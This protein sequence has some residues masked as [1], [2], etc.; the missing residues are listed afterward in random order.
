MNQ[1]IELSRILGNRPLLTP[2]NETG[3]QAKR[4]LKWLRKTEAPTDEMARHAL[5]LVTK[6]A[7]YRKIKY[8]LRIYLLNSV[9]ACSTFKLDEPPNR[10]VANQQVWHQ[11]SAIMSAPGLFQ[12]HRGEAMINNLMVC[13]AEHDLQDPLSISKSHAYLHDM[14]KQ[15]RD[16]SHKAEAAVR[17]VYNG[18]IRGVTRK[19]MGR[20][21]YLNNTRASAAEKIVHSEK[22]TEELDSFSGFGYHRVEAEKLY[23]LIK[24]ALYK[25]DIKSAKNIHE[26]ALKLLGKDRKNNRITILNFHSNLL[27]CYIK[28]DIPK[29]GLEFAKSIMSEPGISE[30]QYF[31]LLELTL[32]LAMKSE[33]Y[34]KA[35]SVYKEIKAHS[36]Y[37]KLVAEKIETFDIIK[38]YISLLVSIKIIPLQ[39]EEDDDFSKFRIQR[40][41]NGLTLSQKE[42]SLRNTH[43]IVIRLLDHCIN[44]R[45]QDFNLFEAIRKYVQRHLSDPKYYRTKNFIL[46]LA[47]YPENGFNLKLTLK[48]AQRHLDRMKKEP[49]EVESVH[50]Y[51]EIIP[52]E[53][54]WKIAVQV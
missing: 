17:E 11:L 49:I 6:S 18:Y 29:E 51:T 15:K 37:N 45:D 50:A 43:A 53:T 23:H 2:N 34:S 10:K 5:S 12:K 13:A 40:F 25:S 28:S 35:I 26:Q 46:A 38:A 16:H 42:K 36:S 1:L 48:S 8:H 4:L 39:D 52:Y 30:F 21:L 14:G 9:A 33:E 54:L 3:K 7:A 27:R 31:I 32:I 24:I 44:K 20:S 47:Y 22:C 41:L 19:Q